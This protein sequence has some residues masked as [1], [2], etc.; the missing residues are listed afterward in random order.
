MSSLSAT[1]TVEFLLILGWL[2]HLHE[3]DV[4]GHARRIPL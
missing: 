3:F 2:R 4:K 1:V